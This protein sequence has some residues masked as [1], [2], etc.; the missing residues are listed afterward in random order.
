MDDQQ[1]A[2]LAKNDPTFSNWN[3][4]DVGEGPNHLIDTTVGA[5]GGFS[6]RYYG[7]WHLLGSITKD[8]NATA[9]D[10]LQMAGGDYEIFRTPILASV[11]APISPGSPITIAHEIEDP[12]Q[13]N[14][15]R[16]HPT[17]GLPEILGQASPSYPLWT[18]RDVFMGFADQI[19]DAAEPTASTCAV[20]DGGRR[21]VMS[22]ELPKGIVV[23]GMEDETVRI[24]L[25]TITSFDQSTPT[26][27]YI[28]TIRPVCANTVRAGRA[29][30]YAKYVVK[31]TKNADLKARYAREALKLVP[32]FTA[33]A[34]AEWDELVNAQLT[35]QKFER[36][37]TDLWR[38]WADG[39]APTTSRGNPAKDV[40]AWDRKLERL[41]W[42]F[43]ESPTTANVRNTGY[44]GVQAVTEFCDWEL[45]VAPKVK[46]G[47]PKTVMTDEQKDGVR[48][49]RS[50]TGEPSVTNPKIDFTEV[51]LSALV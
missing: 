7:G 20:L 19:I 5:N 51:F 43:R 24:W 40:V 50:I 28:T 39:E 42:L 4:S 17:T 34:L 35:N 45:K 31:K 32:T 9:L 48:F 27:T 22:F 8:P 46:A 29:Q 44:A 30:Q 18:P 16:F 23:G 37:V 47:Q 33:A 1:I 49:W 41:N 12:R 2:D 38:P 26:V 3:K 14:I 6:A 15:G 25:V 11:E 10:L 13:V 21:V 36:I